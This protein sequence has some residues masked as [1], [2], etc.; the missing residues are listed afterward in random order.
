MAITQVTLYLD[1]RN[2]KVFRKRCIDL[3]TSAS[4]RL[5]ILMIQDNNKI[6]DKKTFSKI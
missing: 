1:D 5:N 3:N 2:Y 4:Q 6:E